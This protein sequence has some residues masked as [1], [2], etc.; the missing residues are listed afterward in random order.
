MR[1]VDQFSE[2]KS[3]WKHGVIG[4]LV[5]RRSIVI[6]VLIS[7]VAMSTP[8]WW[9]R[10]WS[11]KP[12]PTVSLLTVAI[13]AL[14]LVPLL[15]AY[16]RHRT[17]RSLEVKALLHD[18]AHFL[19]DHQIRMFTRSLQRDDEAVGLERFSDYMRT[20]CEFT[21]D[22]FALLAD[23]ATVNCAIRIAVDVSDPGSKGTQVV[24][25]TVGRSSGLSR[26][27]AQTSEDIPANQGIPRFLIEQHNCMGILR[28][29]NLEEAEK[30]GTFKMTTNEKRFPEEIATMFVAPINGW[31]GKQS[32]MIGL[33]Y[34]TSRRHRVFQQHQVDCVRFVSDVI[35]SSLSFTV[36][37]Y[38]DTALYSA[39]ERNRQ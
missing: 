9:P 26:A 32:S 2:G 36:Q 35:A 7:V 28:Y 30:A 1:C 14:L 4:V 12:S 22:Y 37:R 38:R 23:D 18:L 13:T 17:I 39:I 3:A 27:R 5:R 19:R 21:K 10:E 8:S 16:L 24:Y 31:D 20:L 25:R 33:L 11:S 6:A 15:L 34:I 29:N